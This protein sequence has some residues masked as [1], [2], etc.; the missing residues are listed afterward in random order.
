M[1][2]FLD[3][4]LLAGFMA[5][6]IFAIGP[7][8][9]LINQTEKLANEMQE[10]QLQN[11]EIKNITVVDKIYHYSLIGNDWLVYYTI[12]DRKEVFQEDNRTLYYNV[13]IG[14]T[15]SMEFFNTT[16]IDFVEQG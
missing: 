16:R 11:A 1:P 8:T 3:W 6:V 14:K 15:Y 9:Q 13:E 2:E 7:T 5:A 12:E 4:V 10:S